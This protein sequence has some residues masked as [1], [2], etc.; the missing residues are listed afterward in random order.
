MGR[1]RLALLE[2]WLLNNVGLDYAYGIP[3]YGTFWNIRG[4]CE[5]KFIYKKS[6]ME[7]LISLGITELN[8]VR[9]ELVYG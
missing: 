1:G 3:F 6:P 4:M 5:Y 7:E 2:M 9:S 8:Q